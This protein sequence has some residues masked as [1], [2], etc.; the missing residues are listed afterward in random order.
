MSGNGEPSS[1]LG[2]LEAPLYDVVDGKERG[3]VERDMYPNRF[4]RLVA[5]VLY[6]IV[7]WFSIW[8][9]G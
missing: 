2:D 7:R 1:F 5:S 6:G 8:R 9:R 3:I 4:A